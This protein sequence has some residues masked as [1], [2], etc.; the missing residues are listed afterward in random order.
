M[1][2]YLWEELSEPWRACA[3]E[4]WEAYRAG[5]LP[6]GAV[7][8]DARG[9]VVARG[10]SRIHEPSCPTGAVFGRKLADADLTADRAR[11]ARRKTSRAETP[12]AT[13]S[14]AVRSSR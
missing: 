5:S 9:N 1:P 11:C 12:Q 8:T 14:N 13:S 4:A 10:P 3:E 7:V 2:E 6:I